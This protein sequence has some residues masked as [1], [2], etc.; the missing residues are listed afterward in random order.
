[1]SLKRRKEPCTDGEVLN[2]QDY[3]EILHV[4]WS[5]LAKS[6]KSK[7]QTM[8]ATQ[9]GST[10]GGQCF[11]YTV[12][13]SPESCSFSAQKGFLKSWSVKSI[14]EWAAATVPPIFLAPDF[15]VSGCSSTVFNSSFPSSL[16]AKWWV[17]SLILMSQKRNQGPCTILTWHDAFAAS[18]NHP[19]V[20]VMCSPL[21]PLK[22]RMCRRTLKLSAWL[23][24]SG[25]TIKLQRHGY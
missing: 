24:E 22:W 25:S 18:P 8:I 2:L 13:G 10:L 21:I 4:R 7:G 20:R 3:K 11:R 14:E 23:M 9:F 12:W 16:A 17:E 1:M 6:S 5:T 15:S 19:F